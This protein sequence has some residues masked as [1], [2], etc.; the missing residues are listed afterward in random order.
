MAKYLAMQIQKE[1]LNYDD[2]ILR[3]PELKEEIDTHLAEME[4]RNEELALA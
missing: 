2:V 1:K 3:F 4:V